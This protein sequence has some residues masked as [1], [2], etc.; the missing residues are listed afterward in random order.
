MLCSGLFVQ[1]RDEVQKTFFTKAL[2]MC[3]DVDF[4]V[5]IAM[6]EQLQSIGE[7]MGSDVISGVILN[8]LLELLKDEDMKVPLNAY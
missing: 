6:C 3:Q 7:S 2:A 4:H 5:R 1:T 8:E